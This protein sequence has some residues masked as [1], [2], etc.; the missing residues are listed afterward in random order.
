MKRIG[1]WAGIAISICLLSSVANGQDR[2][3]PPPGK[4]QPR[5][6]QQ[7][8][9]REPRPG[10]FGIGRPGPGGPP[11]GG[12][13]FNF[14]SSEMR[15][16]GRVVKGAPFSGTAVTES[17]QTLADGTRLSRKLTASIWRDGEGRQRREQ[18]MDLVGPLAAA[19]DPPTLIFI[20]DV[21]GGFHYV[22]NLSDHTARRMPPPRDMPPPANNRPSDDRVKTESLGRKTIDGIEAE[23]KRW[24]VTI[25]VG[26]I[27]NDRPLEIVSER[28]ESVE[29]QTL[30]YSRHS[31]PRFGETIFRLTN[32]A[33]SEPEKSLFE[34]P[35]D[36]RVVEDRGPRRGGPR[37]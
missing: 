29:L 35:A 36:Y 2:Q 1:M 28:W 12:P 8:P 24:T 14:L 34:V 11:P 15:F 21:V 23:G 25:P 16:E 10:G 7:P 20:N 9:P 18:K 6:D 32:I 30:I 31:D 37:E 26:E 3:G 33:R 19:G 27:G 17:V 4:R 5:F 13:G 22:L